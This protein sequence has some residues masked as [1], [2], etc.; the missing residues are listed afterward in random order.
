[1]THEEYSSESKE[2]R[3][4]RCKRVWC[5]SILRNRYE[6]ENGSEFRNPFTFYKKE[7]VL[8]FQIKISLVFI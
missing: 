5:T 3:T 6:K 4:V 1:M 8:Q 7:V 2:G